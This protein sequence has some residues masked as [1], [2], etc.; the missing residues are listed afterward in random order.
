VD[1]QSIY[2]KDYPEGDSVDVVVIH[3]YININVVDTIDEAA[4]G[5]ITLTKGESLDIA[6]AILNHFKEQL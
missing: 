2:E 1:G 6:R 5:Y 3:N 4:G